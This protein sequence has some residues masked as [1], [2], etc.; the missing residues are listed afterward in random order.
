MDK[1]FN[2]VL[3]NVS[4]CQKILSVS[5]WGLFAKEE[6]NRVNVAVCAFEKQKRN[7]NV[8]QQAL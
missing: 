8:Q 7:T 1:Y 4:I 3:T 6:S 5:T 2:F